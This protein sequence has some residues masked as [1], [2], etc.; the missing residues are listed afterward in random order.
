MALAPGD[1]PVRFYVPPE[2][3][4]TSLP[5]AVDDYWPWVLAQGEVNGPLARWTGA[6]HATT[7]RTWLQLRDAGFPC[8]LTDELP[9]DGIVVTH[10]DFLPHAGSPDDPPW[11]RHGRLRRELLGAFVVC[12]QADRPRHPFAHVHAVQ[13]GQDAAASGAKVLARM[14][15]LRLRYLPLWTQPGLIPRSDAR[16]DEFRN[17]AFFGIRGELDRSLLDPA[18]TDALRA[19]GFELSIP[20]ADRWHDYGDVDAVVAVRSFRYPGA[21]LWKPPSKLFN[22]WKAGVPAVLGRESA[23]RAERR[24]D[25][26]YLEVRS[27]A[28]LEAAL[29]RLRD[30][31]VLR[32]DMVENGRHRLAEVD[33]EAITRRWADLLRDEA[34]PAYRRWRR[35]PAAARWAWAAR[36]AVAVP[37]EGV[38][39]PILDADRLSRD[40]L[41]HRGDWG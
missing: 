30:D 37:V 20:E 31:P 1:V 35:R 22:A 24:S 41:R 21:W 6:R 17:V 16:G 11:E 3:W 23:Y 15:G 9:D 27:R 36:R 19:R 26:D 14:A 40:V 39:R 33:D 34:V 7:I 38:L 10:T 13:N 18:W 8:E 4:P 25:L 29:A 5:S 28:E 2:W 12:Y 32:K